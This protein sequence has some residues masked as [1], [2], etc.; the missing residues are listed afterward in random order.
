VSGDWTFR[1]DKVTFLDKETRRNFWRRPSWW[2]LLIVLPW[3][4][5]L[6]EDVYEW[7]RYGTAA[8]REKTAVGVITV[9]EAANHNQYRFIFSAAGK[10]Y[11]GFGSLKDV[12]PKIG[13]SVTV[14]YDPLDPTTN[15]LWEFNEL[16][17]RSLDPV[18]LTIAGI[19]AVICTIA[20][21]RHRNP[22]ID[23]VINK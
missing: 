3:S 9:H 15:S 21:M 11:D 13:Q 22:S 14:Y 4:L 10:S 8:S 16:S 19:T 20:W 18:P 17:A 23:K 7:K 1:F 2:A 6:V 5:G 12:E